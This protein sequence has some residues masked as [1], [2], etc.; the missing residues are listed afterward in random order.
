MS[1]D[2]LGS[3]PLF[4]RLPAD[5]RSELAALLQ[6]RKYPEHRPVFWIGEQGE[7]FYIVRT[8]KVVVSCPDEAGKEVV[9]GTLGPGHFFGEI[10]LL[11]GG[12]RTATVRTEADSEL[13]VLSRA[14]FLGFLHRHPDAAIYMLG[15][16]GRRQRE[17]NE[18]LRGIRNVNEAVDARRSPLQRM[19]GRVASIYANE[20]FV[21]GNVL[22]FTAWILI[23]TWRASRGLRPFD[24]PP[25]FFMLG[26]IITVEAILL[27]MFVLN[28]QKQQAERDRIRAD[29]DY[30]V[31]LKAHQEVMQLHHKIDQLQKALQQPAGQSPGE[32][33]GATET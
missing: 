22:F 25:T 17:T 11:D 12:P 13:F 9:L 30:Q 6:S 32:A 18:K 16:L 3:I 29:L 19:A 14:D 2:V 23:N 24:E 8:G 26:F 15:I 27:S 21:I 5:E 28:S 10:S 1:Q 7:D 4:S 31:N 20:L 33:T